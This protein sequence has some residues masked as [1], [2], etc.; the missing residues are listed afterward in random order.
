MG[1]PTKNMTECN[2]ITN[3]G[4]VY[5]LVSLGQERSSGLTLSH[6]KYV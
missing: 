6:N 2:N 5:T 1:D 4:G 3:Q